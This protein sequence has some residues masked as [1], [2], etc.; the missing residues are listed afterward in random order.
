MRTDPLLELFSEC[1]VQVE[2]DGQFSGTGFWVAPGRTLTCA[3][4]VHGGR[5]ISIRT[6]SGVLAAR[7]ASDLLAPGDPA[8]RFYPQPDVALLEVLDAPTDHPCVRLDSSLPAVA[9]D[10]LHLAAYTIGEHAPGELALSGAILHLESLFHEGG[11]HLLKLREGQ[12]VGGFS[13]GPLLNRR[14]GGICG[15]VD[16]SRLVKSALG[17]FGVPTELIADHLTDLLEQNRLFHHDDARWS[18]AVQEQAIADA[19]RGNRGSL[20]HRPAS[21]APTAPTTAFGNAHFLGRDRELAEVLAELGS[22]APPA[23]VTVNG[24]AGIGKSAFADAL[25]ARLPR[26]FG[27]AL[28]RERLHAHTAGH[29]PVDPRDVLHRLLSRSGIEVDPDATLDALQ[30][31]WQQ[32]TAL[33]GTILLLDDALDDDQVLPLLPTPSVNS[34]TIVTSRSRLNSVRAM[35]SSNHKLE[36]LLPEHAVRL[37]CEITGRTPGDEVAAV[38]ALA[39]WCHKV[40]LVLT[41]L[42]ARLDRD[43]RYD[44]QLEEMSESTAASVDDPIGSKVAQALCSSFDRLNQTSR[45]LLTLWGAVPFSEIDVSAIAALASLTPARVRLLLESLVDDNLIERS[46]RASRWYRMHDLVRDHVRSTL[47]PNQVS[48]AGTLECLAA[49]YGNAAFAAGAYF[50]RQPSSFSARRATPPGPVPF[51]SVADAALWARLNRDN[52]ATLADSVSTAADDACVVYFAEGTAALLRNEGLWSESSRLHERAI[53]AADN[54]KNELSRANALHESGVL[55]RLR[56][57][58]HLAESRIQE[59]LDAYRGLDDRLGTAHALNN[60]GV[61]RDVRGDGAAGEHDIESARRIYHE[62]GDQ[63]GIANTEHDLGF[64]KKHKGDL[65]DAVRHYRRALD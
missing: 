50:D 7:A 63:L 53:V 2:L 34:L 19:S 62:I 65:R 32:T 46:D 51:D 42:A 4:V 21:F 41:L 29:G 24:M 26:H 8:A 59:A 56:G 44:T 9:T 39:D 20:S 10:P 43:R 52:L 47:S 22:A 60:R 11:V 38:E 12:I 49:F 54:L 58:N 16:S 23:I 45:H 55:R 27:P 3:H 1:I 13:G 61:I 6:E 17:G 35:R 28:F 5:D 30:E 33:R 37:I 31:R 14:T 25:L 40:P 57:E 64:L 15:I 36:G 18:V 48:E